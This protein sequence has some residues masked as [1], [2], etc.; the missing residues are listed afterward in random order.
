MA[1]A[2]QEA[3]HRVEQ[4]LCGEGHTSGAD[5]GLGLQPGPR[6]APDQI[7]VAIHQ[8]IE[9]ELTA[10]DARL[11]DRFGHPG[12]D[13]A[14][15]VRLVSRVD[16]PRPASESWL[17][18]PRPR[19]GGQRLIHLTPGPARHRLPGT[20]GDLGELRLVQAG[21]HRGLRREP[22]GDAG[23]RE[24]VLGARLGQHRQTL[25]HG[26][27]HTVDA[28]LLR[29]FHQRLGVPGRAVAGDDGCL[30]GQLQPRAVA[31]DVPAE[32]PDT[33]LPQGLH[34]GDTG[35]ATGSGDQHS[36]RIDHVLPA[37]RGRVG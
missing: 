21:V 6:D 14:H 11:Q 18:D 27:D 5:A 8:G 29:Q 35:W 24:H 12:P 20:L 26:A 33:R 13:L 28:V 15:V 4:A 23:G 25:G 30:I 16:V 19:H 2:A 17:D 7:A 3:L 32:H 9:R 36:S 22:G 1:E 37:S 31:V 34:D 10:A